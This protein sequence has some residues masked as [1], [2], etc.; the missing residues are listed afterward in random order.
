MNVSG[1]VFTKQRQRGLVYYAKYRINGVQRKKLLG[2]VWN[3]RGR[4]PEGFY[5][6]KLAEQALQAILTDARRGALPD[7]VGN[8]RT[9]KDACD[10]WLRYTEGEKACAFST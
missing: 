1:H 9:Y 3:E 5:T 4:P 8:R 10:E 6:K 7:P 2:P